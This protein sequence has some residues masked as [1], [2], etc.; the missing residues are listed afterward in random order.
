MT[1]IGTVWAD[2]TWEVNTW[3]ANTWADVSAAEDIAI[4]IGD[5]FTAT[6]HIKQLTLA[7][8]FI[9]QVLAATTER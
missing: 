2:N 6:V 8:Q 4:T 5:I 7:T 1:V 9:K 3:A